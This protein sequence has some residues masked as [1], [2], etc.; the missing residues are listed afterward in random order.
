MS[1]KVQTTRDLLKANARAH[2]DVPF[3]IY[4]NEIVTYK[5]LEERT[6]ALANFLVEQGL[7][8]GDVVSFMMVNSPEFFYTHLGVQKMGAMAV[9]ISCWRQA[10]EVAFLVND[11]RPRILVMDAEYAPIVSQIRK[12]IPSVEEI[13]IHASAD[14]QLDF[15]QERLSG[16]LE[17]F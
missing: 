4:Y 5:D 17:R 1:G 9:P 16:V 15:P 3:L 6:N 11:C 7:K 13:L 14:M 2:P 12:Q 8:A 10:E